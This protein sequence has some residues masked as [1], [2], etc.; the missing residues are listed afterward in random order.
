[1]K[2]ILISAILLIAFVGVQAQTINSPQI[3]EKHKEDAKQIEKKADSKAGSWFEPTLN[4]LNDFYGGSYDNA[5]T[6]Y[7]NILWPD[8]AAQYLSN[9][10]THAWL[11]SMGFVVDPYADWYSQAIDID[12]QNVTNISLDSLY[13]VGWYENVNGV[14]EDTLVF[15][16][17]VDTATTEPAFSNIFYTDSSAF[18]SAPKMQGN[19]TLKGFEARLT[20]PNKYVIKHVLTDQDS[21]M[22][23]GKIMNFAIDDYISSGIDINPE[24]VVGI[25]ATFVPGY[26]YNFG[27]TIFDYDASTPHALKNAMRIGF[28]ATDDPD[29]NPNLFLDPYNDAGHYNGT[30]SIRTDGRYS[31]Y[32]SSS[33][34]NECMLPQTSWGMYIGTYFDYTVGVEENKNTMEMSIHPNPV[35]DQINISVEDYNNASLEV[36]NLLG[37]VVKS[38]TINSPNTNVNVSGLNNGT[39]IV[40]VL[41]GDKVATQKVVINK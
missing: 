10:P 9:G 18:F 6:L 27:D 39:Y 17:V 25:S 4:L 16:I 15:E 11:N 41:S 2:R 32:D 19:S 30:Y 40:R 3:N 20:D 28:Y 8:S 14:F 33:P 31:L 26:S 34:L 5:V 38:E 29:A 37:E 24:E 36:Y 21:T 13:I 35:T 7:S 12:N 1:M 23:G 22:G